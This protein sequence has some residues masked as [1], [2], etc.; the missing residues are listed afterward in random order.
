MAAARRRSAQ[1]RPSLRKNKGRLQ[2]EE[3]GYPLGRAHPGGM[4]LWPTWEASLRLV[5]P[6]GE[7]KTF[8][9]LVPVLRQ[10]P[11][12]AIATSTKADL[13][14]LTAIA[15]ARRARCSRSTLIC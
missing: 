3:I 10:H 8:R 7:G 11:G 4:P 9:A 15:R 12:P 2:P 6:P 1:T 5:A 13:Y 14:E